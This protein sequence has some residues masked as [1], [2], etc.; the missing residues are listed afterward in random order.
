MAEG[1][2][3]QYVGYKLHHDC[4]KTESE[5]SADATTTCGKVI[6]LLIR[7]I[8]GKSD[9][10]NVYTPAGRIRHDS[11]MKRTVKIPYRRVK[12]GYR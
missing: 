6:Q 12:G 1:R 9:N 4:N 2:L 10:L 5:I 7:Q 11:M 3:H 8:K